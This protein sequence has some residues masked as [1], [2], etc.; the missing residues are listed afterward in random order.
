MGRLLRYEQCPECGSQD[1]LAVYTDGYYCFTPKC[2]HR[3]GKRHPEHFPTVNWLDNYA[4]RPVQSRNL[5]AKTCEQLDI[6]S[7]GRIVGFPYVYKGVRYAVKY[8]DFSFPKKQRTMHMHIDGQAPCT[9]FGWQALNS[10]KIVAIA[11]GEFDAA[12]VIQLVRIPCLSPP[13]GDKSIVDTVKFHL[14]DLLKFQEVVLIPDNDASS[15]EA[16][17]EAAELLHKDQVK[18]VS[19]S[20]D[21]PSAYLQRS[22]YETFRKAFYAAELMS[23]NLL[24]GSIK[25]NKRKCLTIAN[26][27]PFFGKDSAIGSLRT[28]EVT[29]LLGR[30][31]QGKSTCARWLT[32]KLAEYGYRSGVFSLEETPESYG[33]VLDDLFTNAGL[34]VDQYVTMSSIHGT[35]DLQDFS[36]AFTAMVKLHGCAVIVID[37]LTAAADPKNTNESLNSLMLTVTSLAASLN[38]HVICISHTSRTAEDRAALQRSKGQDISAPR[39]SDGFGSSFLEKF[40]WNYLTINVNAYGITQINIEKSRRGNRQKNRSF[41]F[42]YANEHYKLIKASIND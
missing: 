17:R 35:L 15:N 21:D 11:A 20:L 1:N 22:N 14:E 10:N 5:T 6:R 24:V 27:I 2:K 28:G 42:T 12:S 8:R 4:V 19:L 7:S 31:F 16:F 18:I 40:A 37:N 34:D 41:T 33:E 29:I 26:D 23:T 30:A 32:Y 39:L 3:K 38:V 25:Q 13:N 9:F 36:A